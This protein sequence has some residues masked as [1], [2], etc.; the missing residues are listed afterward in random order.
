VPKF[1]VAAV[2]ALVA[3]AL[4]FTLWRAF[5]PAK[6]APLVG[7]TTVERVDEGELRRRHAEADAQRPPEF[8]RTFEDSL[9]LRERLDEATARKVLPHLSVDASVLVDPVT[10][11]RRRPKLDYF[12][13]FP[14]HP[15]GR[16]RVR[17]NDRGWREDADFD[18][19]PAQ[20]RILA[21]GDS[22]SEGACH[23]HESWPNV[24]ER[25][26]SARTGTR[27]V[28]DNASCAG[29]SVY[30]HLGV[31]EAYVAA[32][33][34]GIGP[35]VFA[36]CIYGGN[37]LGE[38]LLIHDRVH[39]RPRPPGAYD[40]APVAELVRGKD[41]TAIAQVWHQLMY[42]R[43]NPSEAELA[44]DVLAW[45]L[46]DM[47][48]LCERHGIVFLPM[49]LPTAADVE[50]EQHPFFEEAAR[51][52]DFTA[53]DRRLGERWRD[54]LFRRTPDLDWLDLTDALSGHADG[55]YWRSD[56]HIN[57][58]GQRRVARA[59]LERLEERGV[60]ARLSDDDVR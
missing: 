33:P 2:S 39:R 3:A 18:A 22:H 58:A 4:A 19:T 44:L 48:R 38:A 54:G 51:L 10:I 8:F 43:H 16:F 36:P 41:D 50:W 30:N 56:K 24:L 26:L 17:T 20:L 46:D 6:T 12:A 37:D 29:H 1:L 57:L 5:G 32:H 59:V 45:A 28:V 53:E 14:E 15:D 21:A 23:N 7:I 25:M 55:S 27:V 13:T 11:F 35:H 42:L 60:T 34:R 31:L 47:R 40:Y 49:W 9:L 52:Q